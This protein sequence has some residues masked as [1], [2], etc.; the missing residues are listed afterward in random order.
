EAV[1]AKPVMALRALAGGY[2]GSKI[3]EGG[4]SLLGADPEQQQLWGDVGNLAG[5]FTAASGLPR[6]LLETPAKNF[7]APNSQLL[8]DLLQPRKALIRKVQQVS[9]LN[10]ILDAARRPTLPEPIEA[11]ASKQETPAASVDELLQRAKDA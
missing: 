1:A 9:G 2:A 4:A 7:A 8:L 3:A 5:G 10:D 11:A 6:A